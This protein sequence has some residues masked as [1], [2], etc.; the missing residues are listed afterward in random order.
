MRVLKFCEQQG[1]RFVGGNWTLKHKRWLRQLELPVPLAQQVFGEEMLALDQAEQRLA[2]LDAQIKE[3]S[4]TPHYA[5][6]VGLLRCLRGIDT[7]TAMAQLTELYE[8]WRFAKARALMGYLGLVAGERSSG[9]R[10]QSTGLTKAG[11]AF[12]RRLLIEAAWHYVKHP[13]RVS[14]AQR[15][16]QEGQPPEAVAL[17]QRA[18]VRLQRRYLYL[19]GQ[20]KRKTVAIAA[21]ARELCGFLWA[22]PQPWADEQRPAVAAA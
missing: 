10:Q 12:L 6:A 18:M 1:V 7:L 9:E 22:L 5:K 14:Q 17:A 15:A 8:F 21:I 20:G 13:L 19:V 2:R 11:N 3:L 16:K 4:V